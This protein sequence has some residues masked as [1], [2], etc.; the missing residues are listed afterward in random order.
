MLRQRLHDVGV[1]MHRGVTL[2]QIETAGVAGSDEF[3]ES[4]ALEVDGV[5]LVTQRLSNEAL[6]LDLK[7]DPAALAEQGIE[8]VH[9]AGDCVSPRIIADAIFDG[10]RLARE[11]DSENPAVPL[12]FKRERMVLTPV[13]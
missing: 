13:A 1:C 6:Y 9:R 11:I 4:F 3:G 12:P 5:V 10:H 2:E 7:S 8:A